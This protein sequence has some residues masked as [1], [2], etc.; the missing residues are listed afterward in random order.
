LYLAIQTKKVADHYDLILANSEKA[1]IPLSFLGIKQPLVVILHNPE[2]PLRA[3]FL[4][5]TGIARKWSGIG[6]VSFE[7]K[8]FFEKK[9]GVDPKNLFQYFS[10]R[11]D[12][13][14][15][16]E[17][18]INN[19]PILSIGVAKRDYDT[20]IKALSDLVGY[21]TEIF[22]S[23]KYG[24]LY[25]GDHRRKVPDWIHFPPR[26]TDEELVLRYQ[27]A[28]FVVVPLKPTYHSGA[29]VTSVFESS[30]S[31]KAVIATN[32][33]GMKSYIEDG[34]TGILVPPNNVAALRAAIKTL[35][36]NPQLSRKMGLAGRKLMEEKFNNKEVNKRKIEFLRDLY[37]KSKNSLTLDKS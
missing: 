32:T 28:N 20:L 11:I 16:A 19:G 2:S 35:W 14:K 3:F 17:D 23:S 1:A 29:G 24:D 8:T 5:V 4:K 37:T 13:F 31:G 26:L 21:E 27:R 36:E 9:L 7:N 10:A 22:I 25:K 18:F 12:K 33:G 34:N 6:F 15:P 30:A